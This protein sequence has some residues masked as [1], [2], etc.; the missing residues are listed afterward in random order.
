MDTR[1]Q[2]RAGA[3]TSPDLAAMSGDVTAQASKS[4][5]S[6]KQSGSTK[7][8]DAF[9]LTAHPSRRWR[10]KHQAKQYYFGGLD[11]WQAALARYQ[12]E[13]RCCWSRAVIA[14]D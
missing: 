3:R 12:H 2:A 6:G 1:S 14:T 7:P 11:D 9:P 5:Q 8:Y 4:R 10:K 13:W